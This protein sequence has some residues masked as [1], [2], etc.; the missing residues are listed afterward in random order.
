M[1]KGRTCLICGK[2]YKFCR[3]CTGKEPAWRTLFDSDNCYAIYDAI[4]NVKIDKLKSLDLSE[5]TEEVQ[6]QVKEMIAQR[7]PKKTEEVEK[8]V[9]TNQET[10]ASVE[11]PIDNKSVVANKRKFN[12]KGD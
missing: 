6:N 1:E 11:K 4:S 12:H 7:E 10:A 8:A 9:N 3:S 5:A 2:K